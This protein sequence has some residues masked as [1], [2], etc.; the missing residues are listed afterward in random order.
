M[1]NVTKLERLPVKH[2][3]HFYDIKRLKV[4][5]RGIKNKYDTRDALLFQAKKTLLKACLQ[6]FQ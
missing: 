1:N 2:F 3:Q 4:D 5:S 6:T